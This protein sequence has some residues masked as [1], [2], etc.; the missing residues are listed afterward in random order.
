M[1]I[2]PISLVSF[3]SKEYLE[4]LSQYIMP[5]FLRCDNTGM[6]W[7]PSYKSQKLKK[8]LLLPNY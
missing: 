4:T 3:M 8:K 7:Y 6:Y 1:D 2:G 5:I